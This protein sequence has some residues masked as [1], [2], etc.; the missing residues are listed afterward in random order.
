MI[1]KERTSESKITRYKEIARSTYKYN[2]IQ[3]N[4]RK[5]Q[6]ISTNINKYKQIWNKNQQ[7]QTNMDNYQQIST[8][9][10]K[11]KQIS[12]TGIWRNTKKYQQR[13]EKWRTIKE[14]QQISINIKMETVV[15]PPVAFQ[16]HLNRLD[17]MRIPFENDTKTPS[18]ETELVKKIRNNQKRKNQRKKSRKCKK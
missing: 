3:S 15:D 7:I 9:T 5:D 12:T 16:T 1:K 17:T 18:K 8:T 2:Q 4:M 13:E 14:Y 6:Q 10:N 11:Y